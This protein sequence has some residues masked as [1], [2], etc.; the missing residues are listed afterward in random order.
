MHNGGAT[1]RPRLFCVSIRRQR[2]SVRDDRPST[3]GDRPST[4]GD[5]PSPSGNRPPTRDDRP[6]V[7]H[8]RPSTTDDRPSTTNVRPSATDDR[9]STPA[10]V[11]QRPTIVHQPPAIVHQ[12]PTIV[13]QPP[14]IVHQPPAIVHQPPAIVH[15]PPTIVHQPPTIVHQPPTIVHQPPAIVHQ[16][17]T[18]VHQPPAI[19]RQPPAIIHQLPGIV[20]QPPGIVRR[21]PGIVRQPPRI[22]HQPVGIVHQ[23][24][25]TVQ[26]PLTHSRLTPVMHRRRLRCPH[27]CSRIGRRWSR[28]AFQR[29]ESARLAR[30]DRRRASG[31]TLQSPRRGVR[32]A[33]ELIF[34][35]L[36]LEPRNH[37]RPLCGVRDDP[38]RRVHPP[39]HPSQL[40]DV[41]PRGLV[42]RRVIV[43]MEQRTEFDRRDPGA[44]VAY[45]HRVIRASFANIDPRRLVARRMVVRMQQRAE[46]DR[47]NSRARVRQVIAAEIPAFGMRR[48]I[49]DR[50]ELEVRELRRSR[51][52]PS[53]TSAIEL[54]CGG[55]A[56]SSAALSGSLRPI[57]S[58]FST[59]TISECGTVGMI[60]VPA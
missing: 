33:R 42:A 6:S 2:P 46:L 48:A 56:P 58:P 7:T 47:R 21:P 38:T 9:P 25:V 24:S 26:S 19:V 15:Q 3:S 43:G 44:R 12:R 4:S 30:R 39:G 41:D 31:S 20:H 28:T 22:V 8:D 57:M 13:H 23:S 59:A 11:H 17:P 40:R 55:C 52:A 27:C 53:S 45:I 35:P 36:Q 50:V 37:I 51:G 18:I 14:A 10:F 32:T 1:R 49:P 60:H 29:A 34:S 54:R 5:R 16:R